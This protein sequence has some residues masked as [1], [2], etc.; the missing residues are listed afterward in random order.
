MKSRIRGWCA[1]VLFLPVIAFTQ[2]PGTPPPQAPALAPRPANAPAPAPGE[3]RIHLDVVVTDKAGKPVAGLQAEDFTLKDNN[4]PAKILSFHAGG[5]AV[6]KQPPPVEVILLLDAVNLG[7][8]AVARSRDQIVDFLRQ[9]GGRLPQPVSIFVFGDDGIKVLLQPST[10]GNAL[11]D[12]LAKSQT[13]LRS[14]GRSAQ[15]GGFERFD[16][17]LKWMDLVARAVA[18]RPGKKLLV[19]AGP[20]WP[21]LDRPNTGM[22]EKAEQQMFNEIVALSTTLREAQIS[23]YSVTMGD[24]HLGTFLYEDFLKGVKTA[25]KAQPSDLALKVLAV[26]SGGRVTPPDNDITAQITT[27]VQDARAYYTISFN[28]PPADKA[29]EYHDL[30]VEV[31]KPGLTARTNTGYYNQP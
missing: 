20:G 3:G 16:L 10:D 17:S 24:S 11:A 29:N 28:P 8:Q 13:A 12:Q 1:G 30:K 6:E 31:D 22:S 14:I 25:E 2:E 4:L 7:F 21:M 18:K 19:W 27:C 5:T 23:V 15:Y 26:Q 9:N